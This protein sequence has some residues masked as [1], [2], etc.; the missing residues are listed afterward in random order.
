MR[1]IFRIPL[2]GAL[3]L[4]L[5]FV[6]AQPYNIFCNLT[7]KCEALY[8]SSLLP[9]REGKEPINIVYEVNSRRGDM[10]FIPVEKELETV[11]GRKNIVHYK[12]T[13]VAKHLIRFRPIFYVKPD[14]VLR[15]IDRNDCICYHEYKLKKGETIELKLE[16]R[17]NSDFDKMR[18]ELK[19]DKD[20]IVIG[21][22]LL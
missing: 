3:I 10:D 7:K 17:I 2:Y 4:L 9:V 22:K 20:P 15:F 19:V 12:V 6:L 11:T 8:L 1:P 21:F 18:D 13:N 16:Y 5:F 14:K